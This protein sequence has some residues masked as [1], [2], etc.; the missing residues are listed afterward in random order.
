[1]KNYTR[2][3]ISTDE[4]DL[5]SR[6]PKLYELSKDA[7]APADE[8]DEDIFRRCLKEAVTQGYVMELATG[9]RAEF[10]SIK[11]FW[12]KKFWS[13]FSDDTIVT[14][15]LEYSERGIEILYKYYQTVYS[16]SKNKIV[17]TRAPYSYTLH[18]EKIEVP[19]EMDLI[20]VDKENDTV[21]LTVFTDEE[22]VPAIKESVTSSAKHMVQLSSIKKEIPQGHVCKA[23]FYNIEKDIGYTMEIT[24][25][26][27]KDIDRTIGYLVQGIHNKVYFKSKTLIC[28]T[29]V[30]KIECSKE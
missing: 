4:I 22:S 26:I 12:D 9:N 30:Y 23:T 3:Q 17:A 8:D 15:A 20:S 24:D 1:M 11:T 14:K 27:V 13:A 5:Y 21:Y 28:D 7:V 2:K 16:M 19:V 25:E 29:C 10:S 6:C 18:N